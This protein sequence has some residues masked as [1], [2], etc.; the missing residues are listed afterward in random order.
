MEKMSILLVFLFYSRFKLMFFSGRAFWVF[1][2]LQ[3]YFSQSWAYMQFFVETDKDG[4]STQRTRWWDCT[5]PLSSITTETT[6]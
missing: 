3:Y 2:L 1:E 4:S 6:V 5:T